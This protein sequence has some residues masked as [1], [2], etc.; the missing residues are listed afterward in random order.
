MSHSPKI[1]VVMSVYNG[2]A[3]LRE[4]IESILTQTFNDF[5][6]IIINDGSIDNSLSIIKSYNDNRIVLV[7]NDGNKGLIYSLNKGLEISKGDYIA[8]MDADDVSLPNRFQE[9]INVFNAHKDAVVVSS[10]FY[11]LYN[12]KQFLMEHSLKSDSL[13]TTLLFTPCFC[14][15]T[16]MMKNIFKT[17]NIAYQQNYIH[18]EDYKLWTDLAFC[19]NFY[20]V[21]K[22]LFKY[23]SHDKQI[24]VLHHEKQMEISKQIRS[25]YLQ[26]LNFE[27]SSK[28][29]ATLNIIGNN[30]FITSINTLFD[31]E[32]CLKELIIQNRTNNAF[33][34]L[35][36]NTVIHKFWRDSC[37]YT[38]LG[39]KA[40]TLFFKSDLYRSHNSTFHDKAKLLIKCII[41]KF[42]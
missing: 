41:R 1:S 21:R 12:N 42:K 29:I 17:E 22:A 30:E 15:P 24:S 33:N 40:Y 19:G 5:E 37:G 13:K 8:R 23:R 35:D 31:V 32:N 2:Q 6:F 11:S 27:L 39:I 7:N 4:A 26:R 28:Q 9:Q 36:F 16:V 18:A 38:N 14:H 3:Y 34:S 10:D 20:F 25:E